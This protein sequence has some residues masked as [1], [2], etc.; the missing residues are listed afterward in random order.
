MLG[1]GQHIVIALQLIA[2]GLL[3]ELWPTRDGK[4][5]R[6][7]FCKGGCRAS[8]G[9]LARPVSVSTTQTGLL[10]TAGPGGRRAGCGSRADRRWRRRVAPG[11]RPRSGGCAGRGPATARSPRA[12]GEGQRSTVHPVPGHRPV[13]PPPRFS[14]AAANSRLFL[15]QAVT[16]LR[17]TPKL[18]LS[19]RRLLR[20]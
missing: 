20:S 2:I 6:P 16:G 18:R 5:P 3:T 13:G 9:D 1:G 4:S 8:G 10:Y 15:S 12:D 17:D 14:A 7:P 11:R 19:P